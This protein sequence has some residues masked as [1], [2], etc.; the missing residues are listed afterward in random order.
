MYIFRLLTLSTIIMH[1]THNNFIVHRMQAKL[2]YETPV[3]NTHELLSKLL[4]T[5]I[6]VTQG[7]SDNLVLN[8]NDDPD[9][10]AS[11]AISDCVY[12]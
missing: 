11:K 5:T 4:Q 7:T 3:T 8:D 2:N 9:T 10:A 6:C 1:A 12:P